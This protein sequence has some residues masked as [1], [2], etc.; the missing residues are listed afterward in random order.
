MSNAY[1]PGS[2]SLK[3]TPT[4]TIKTCPQCG[5]DVE[6][7][8]IDLKMAC[9]RCGFVVYNNLQSCIQWCRLAEACVGEEM[10]A[11][12]KRKPATGSERKKS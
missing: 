11:Q 8:S 10:Y 3:G 12:Y 6:L 1:C 2:A 7:F 4:L 9:D 5:A